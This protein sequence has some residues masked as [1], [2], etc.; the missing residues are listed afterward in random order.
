MEPENPLFDEFVLSAARAPHPRVCFLPTASGDTE[1]YVA[2]FYRAFAR[3]DC[4]PSD[5]AAPARTT[6]ARGSGAR[7]TESSWAQASWARA[8]RPTTGRRSSSKVGS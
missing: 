2:G 6:T 3:L 8:G 7:S 1:S 4:R 5:R